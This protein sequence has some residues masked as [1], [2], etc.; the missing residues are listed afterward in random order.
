MYESTRRDRLVPG[1]EYTQDVVGLL[2]L[3][4]LVSTLTS[5]SLGC[6]TMYILANGLLIT[7]QIAVYHCTF[8]FLTAHFLGHCTL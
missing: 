6:T 7:A 2:D 3:V 1:A 5:R 4:S 8:Q